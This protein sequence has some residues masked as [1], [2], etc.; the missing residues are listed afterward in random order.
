LKVLTDFVQHKINSRLCCH[1]LT[2]TSVL[3]TLSA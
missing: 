3:P 2:V 1:L